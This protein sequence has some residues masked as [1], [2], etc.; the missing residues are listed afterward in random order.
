L[1]LS[2]TRSAL[3]TR[4]LIA[5]DLC[6]LSSLDGMSHRR[7]DIFGRVKIAVMV[8]AALWAIPLSGSEIETGQGVAAPTASFRGR[9]EAVH[10]PQ[11]PSVSL[12]LVSGH[13]SELPE[14]RIRNRLSKAVVFNHPTHVQVFDTNSVVSSHQISGHLIKVVFS[15][16]ADMFLQFGNA[17]ALPVPPTPTLGAAGED[18]L[19]L[20]KASLVF[21]RMLR[22]RDPLTVAGSSQA[23]NSKIDSNR[24]AG[25]FQLGKLF[26]QAE[27]HEV[28]PAGLLDNSDRGGVRGEGATPIHVQT[29]KPTYNQVWVI[30]VGAGELKS[31]GGVFGGLPMPPLLKGGIFA[32]LIKEPNESVVQVTER[33]LSWHGGNFPQPGRSFLFLPLGQLG[34]GLIVTNSL[35]AHLPGVRAIPQSPVIRIPTAAKDLSQSCLLLGCWVKSILVTNLHT[36]RIYA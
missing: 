29:S 2:S 7:V 18:S 21:A 36:E 31:R 22:V 12:T 23:A 35:L 32:L 27:R 20:G 3:Q 14:R 13:L 15:G 28:T 11:L 4:R 19:F 30:G 26:I 33:L 24:F 9:E 6:S 25:G 34:R 5:S 16:V 1:V 17:D 10:S 8:L